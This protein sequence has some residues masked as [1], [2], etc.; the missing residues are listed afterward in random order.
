MTEGNTKGHMCFC[1]EDDCNTGATNGPK[2]LALVASLV[3]ISSTTREDKNLAM[4]AI[5]ALIL[6]NNDFSQRGSS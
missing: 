4:G 1:E 3:L 6:A 5:L 2:N